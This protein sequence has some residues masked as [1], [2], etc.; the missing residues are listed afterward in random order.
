MATKLY[1]MTSIDIYEKKKKLKKI[2]LELNTLK[3]IN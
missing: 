2:Q 3:K 1:Q